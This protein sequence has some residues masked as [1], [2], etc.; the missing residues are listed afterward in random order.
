MLICTICGCAFMPASRWWLDWCVECDVRNFHGSQEL[1]LY[2]GQPP[3]REVLEAAVVT[4]LTTRQRTA[5]ERLH[6]HWEAEARRR[7]AEGR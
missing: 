5:M 6:A 7:V 3:A 2:E 1:R 4:P